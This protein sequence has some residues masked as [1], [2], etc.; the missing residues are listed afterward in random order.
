MLKNDYITE[1]VPIFP[2]AEFQPGLRNGCSKLVMAKF[3][4]VIFFQGDHNIF[5][6]HNHRHI[7]LIEKAPTILM[8]CHGIHIEVMIFNYLFEINISILMLL[9]AN[10]AS[11]K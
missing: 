7:L 4:I 9:V 5:K 11:I 10:L 3:V 8:Q 6:L 1:K 2:R